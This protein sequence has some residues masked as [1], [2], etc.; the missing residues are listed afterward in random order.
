MTDI[1]IFAVV[2]ALKKHL[3]ELLDPKDPNSIRGRLD[4]S[5][6]E[7]YEMT[8]TSQYRAVFN[9]VELG[10]MSARISKPKTSRRV[11][12][13]YPEQVVS[14]N[15]EL[16][17]D[18]ALDNAEHLAAWLVEQGY[19]EIEGCDVVLEEYPASYQG[20]TVSGFKPETVA[21]AFGE[22]LAPV[23]TALLDG[24]VEGLRNMDERMLVQPEVAQI[25][26]E[27]DGD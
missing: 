17:R 10:K 5:M 27:V 16:L 25:G 14:S 11:Y 8:G 13:N 20:T 12:V 21:I 23:V 6:A 7:N 24:D 22:L 9:G 3:D 1:Q 2:Y 18:F 4:A 15:E 26:G 19:A